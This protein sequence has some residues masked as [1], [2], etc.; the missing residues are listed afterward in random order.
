MAKVLSKKQSRLKRKKRIRKKIKGTDQMP[1]LAVF[2]SSRHIYAQLID[3]V[4]G[5][6]LVSASSLEKDV[7]EKANEVGDKTAMAKHIGELVGRRAMEK[8]FKKIVFDRGGFLY[9][10]RIKSLSEGARAAGLDF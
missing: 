5:Y 6:T 1:R 8:G 4:K 9:H 7:R 3:D 10:G 2:K